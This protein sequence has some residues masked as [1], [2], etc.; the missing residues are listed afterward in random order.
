MCPWL[1]W[2]HPPDTCSASS[3]SG[4]VLVGEV[5]A[6]GR[7][8]GAEEARPAW[9]GGGRPATGYFTKRLAEDRLRVEARQGTLPGSVRT[10]PRSPDAAAE[11]LH[12]VEHDRQR[13]PST[14]AGYRA[15]VRSQLLPAFGEMP[16]ESVTTPVIE[17]S[18][19]PT[20][21]RDRA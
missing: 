3:A 2:L 16:L 17:N 15:I 14:L 21:C 20:G 10:G 6:A 4:G 11:W 8:A 18:T 1:R 7:A 9:T 13:K 19:S 12:Y 5:P